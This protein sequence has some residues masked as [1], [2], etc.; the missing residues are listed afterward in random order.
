MSVRNPK[1]TRYEFLGPPGAAAITT[2][3][4]IVVYGLYYSCSEASGVCQLPRWSFPLQVARATV[5]VNWWKG[6]FDTQVTVA[7]FTWYAFLVAAW[8]MLP[9]EWLEGTE[10]R[11]G[12]RKKYKLNGLSTFLLNM[13][14]VTGWISVFGPRS[15]TFLYDHWV[16]LCTAVILNSLVHATYCYF[17]STQNEDQRLLALGGN[18][19]NMIYDW[20]I[21]RELNPS[22]GSFD[23]KSFAELRPGMILWFMINLSSTCK[24]LTSRGTWCPTDSMMLVVFFQGVY[25]VDTLYNERAI[26]TTMDITTDGFGFMLSFGSIAWVPLTYSLQARYLAFNHVEL[27]LF[28]SSVIF[29]IHALGYWIFRGSNNEKDGFRSGRN[30]KSLTSFKT[31]RGTRLLTSGWWGICQHPNY[32]GDWIMALSYSLPTGFNT[33]ITYFYCSY[34][35]VL[36]I[37]RQMRDEEACRKKYGKDW[38]TYTRIV[39]WKIVPYIY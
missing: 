1:T 17:M 10:L 31:E 15:F 5:N 28:W 6:I 24:Q 19:G 16:G 29:M 25:I 37:H 13:G 11:I 3:T 32:M 7:Y 2:G 33:P 36:L 22:I 39:P 14:L 27:G 20:F 8:Y 38:E 18:T 4:P 23:I 26:L 21:G 35:L 34:F 30:P 9:G 12:G